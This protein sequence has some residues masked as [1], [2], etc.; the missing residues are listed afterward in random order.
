[1]PS[2]RCHCLPPSRPTSSTSDACPGTATR[3]PPGA[4]SLSRRGCCS[5]RLGWTPAHGHGQKHLLFL[6][7]ASA[8][9]QMPGG[10]LSSHWLEQHPSMLKQPLL[11]PDVENKLLRKPAWAPVCSW[12]WWAAAAS[13]SQMVGSVGGARLEGR[14]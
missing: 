10:C 4:N 6:P 7:A 3:Q 5:L 12:M 9:R 2:P 8:P 14:Y 13:G 1:V 11:E